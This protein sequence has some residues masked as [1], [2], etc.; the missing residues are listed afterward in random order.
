MQ[1]S[2]CRDVVVPTD[3]ALNLGATQA[4]AK[5]TRV[6]SEHPEGGW[7]V[8]V[9]VF[10]DGPLVPDRQSSVRL[11]ATEEEARAAGGHTAWWPPRV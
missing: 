2:I 7:V 11:F 1:P 4:P 8:N 6:W 5:V 10:A 9:R 3:P